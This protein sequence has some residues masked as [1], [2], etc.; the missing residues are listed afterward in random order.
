MGIV[1]II[2]A[3][4]LISVILTGLVL[5]FINEWMFDKSTEALVST[6]IPGYNTI[7]LIVLVLVL[8]YQSVRI[9]LKAHRDKKRDRRAIKNYCKPE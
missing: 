2:S 3:I 5:A 7:V 6:F 9:I 4:Y 1:F 8:A